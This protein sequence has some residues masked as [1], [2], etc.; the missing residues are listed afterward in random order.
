MSRGHGGWQ[1]N[2]W[3]VLGM[4]GGCNKNGRMSRMPKETSWDVEKK[5]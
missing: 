3:K 5:L 1:E 2:I 4:L